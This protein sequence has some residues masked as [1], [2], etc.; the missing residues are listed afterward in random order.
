MKLEVGS[1]YITK[2]HRLADLIAAIQAMG[3]YRYSARTVENWKEILG[4]KP[5]SAESWQ[6]IFNDHPEFFRAGVSDD[7]L[8]SLVARRSQGRTYNTQTGSEITL[9]QFSSLVGKQRDIISRKPLSPEQ[10][11]SLVQTAI[12]LQNQAVTRAQ[13]LRWWVPTLVAIASLVIGVLT[14][15]AIA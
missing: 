13:E 11:Q 6:T 14:G 12:N 10:I 5:R 8:H 7:G 3:S 9:E 1:P 4:E 2:Q 15:K